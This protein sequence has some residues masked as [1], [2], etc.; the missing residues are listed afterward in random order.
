MSPDIKAP[1]R[2][3]EKVPTGIEG[4]DEITKGGLPK[5]RPTLVVGGP[6]SGKTL[7]AI[8]FLVNGA[9]KF[10]DPGVF[11][12]FEES[13]KEL[14][15][16]SA[17][18]GFD[19]KGLT[20][21]K[22]LSIDYVRIEP[23]K[24]VESGEFDLEGLFIR[25][26]N[27]IDTMG[28]KRVALDTIETIFSSFQNEGIVRSEMARLFRY[29]KDKGVTA[30]VT[31]ESGEGTIS[32]HGLEEY[33]SDMVITLD[34]RVVDEAATRRLRVV[35]YRG[36]SHGTNEY[37]FLIDADG[38]S[39]LPLTSV[40]LNAKASNKRVSTGVPGLDKMMGGRGFFDGSTILITGAA[41][42]GKTSLAAHFVRKTCASGRKTLFLAFE[43]SESQLLRNMRSVGVNLAPYVE[44][45]RLMISSERSTSVGLEMHLA[46][47]HKIIDNFR[48]HVVV[49]DQI[50]SFVGLGSE[51]EA[52]SVLVRLADFLKMKGITAMF[53][54]LR[55]S[56]EALQESI[57]SSIVD[58]WIRLEDVES[59]GEKNRLI[60][61]VKSRGMAHSNQLREFELRNEGVEIIDPY[62]GPAG[63]LTG[64]A[65]FAQQEKER[66]EEIA[67]SAEM[68]RLRRELESQR[69]AMD[70]QIGSLKADMA[71]KEAALKKKIEGEVVR[72][73]AVEATRRR[74]ESIRLSSG[75]TKSGKKEE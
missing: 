43:E 41:G 69:S 32:R 16:N 1:S 28:A 59:N 35:K 33:I 11:V 5:G 42:T 73:K 2:S 25:L 39:V 53:T 17:S 7:F 52:K 29:L 66:A 61:I 34:N 26:N 10:G 18:I 62:I 15:E 22:M 21:K 46:N 8:E 45:G 49:F 56:N 27:A 75:G 19:L 13:D 71:L 36:S 70:L 12:S 72:S 44:R 65:R 67:R 68:E 74:I 64:T 40:G 55:S 30:V 9:V 50:S 57:I 60:R 14:I 47:I 51:S 23:E 20:S 38:I 24:I 58:T 48:P 6:G 54:E 63:I 3:L 37:P 4:F 31:G